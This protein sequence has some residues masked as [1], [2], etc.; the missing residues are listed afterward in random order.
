MGKRRVPQRMSVS[1][2][3][4]R[5]ATLAVCTG[6][7]M[8]AVVI[9][10]VAMTALILLLSALGASAAPSALDAAAQDALVALYVVQ[11]VGASFFNHTAALRFAAIPGLL[12]VGL[13]I[14]S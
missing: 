14:A 13:A 2:L 12:L 6:A 11:L 3:R 4:V 7:A 9:G 10:L 5:A 1:R 8:S